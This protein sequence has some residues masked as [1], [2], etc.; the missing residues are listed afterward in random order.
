MDTMHKNEQMLLLKHFFSKITGLVL[1]GASDEEGK[2]GSG[3]VQS[4]NHGFMGE[5]YYVNPRYTSLLNKPCYPTVL[6]I[7][8]PLS[9]AIIAVARDRVVQIVQECAEKGIQ[10]IVIISA[11]FKEYDEKGAVLEKKLQDIAKEHQICLLGPN[12]LG[13]IHT[14]SSLNATFLPAHIDKGCIS[15]ISQSGG[16][17][18]ALISALQDRGCGLQS[19]VGIGNEAALDAV[20]FL[21]YF[22]QDEA[23]KVIAVCFEGLRDLP[24]FLRLAQKV[25]AVKPVV[26]LRDGVSDVGMQA[27]ISHT[28]AMAQS[29]K[30][31]SQIIQSLELLEAD[32]VRDCAVMLEA[33][34]KKQRVNGHNVCALSNTAGPAIL[35]VDSAR[36]R[37]LSFPQPGKELQDRIDTLAQK[38]L[39]LKNPADISSHGLSPQTYGLAANELLKDSQYDILLGFFSLNKHLKLPDGQLVQAEKEAKKPVVACFLGSMAELLQYKSDTQY[40]NLLC[41]Y[42]P[43][44][45]AIAA[46]ALCSY[47]NSTVPVEKVLFSNEQINAMQSFLDKFPQTKTEHTLSEVDS[48]AFLQLAGLAA[49]APQHCKNEAHAMQLADEL[50]YP[51]VLKLHSQ[52]ITHKSDVGGVRLNLQ[53]AEEVAVAYREMMS[54]LRN[55][56]KDAQLSVQ[57]QQKDGFELIL[58][59]VNSASLGAVTMVGLGG[60]YA[61][62]LEDTQF[63]LGA[64]DE[65]AALDMLQKL[66]CYPILNGH[67]GAVLD[68]KAV[69]KQLSKLSVLLNLFPRIRE[70]ECN[71]CRVYSNGCIALDAR[72]VL[73]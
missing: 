5:V 57:K 49:S 61:E 58:G 35:A 51:V 29:P 24:E 68:V 43:H 8:R 46:C 2:I 59:M 3:L 26:L 39:G 54:A 72:V 47:P 60:V 32:N 4:L 1:V 40:E 69:A 22:A 67:R 73:M 14:P 27:A 15:V 64:V 20:A 9:H 42:D 45:A 50:G 33:L 10:N 19:W 38:P 12:T 37:G 48:Q 34:S 36:K 7:N 13:F 18:M 17:G 6:D 62:V 53:N 56:D 52:V 70:I 44:D 65:N 16:V 31:L 28:G 63:R 30:V 55:H 66:R 41:Y 21:N 23:T 25:N 11:G 71:P